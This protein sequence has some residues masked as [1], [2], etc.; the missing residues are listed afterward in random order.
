VFEMVERNDGLAR[1]REAPTGRPRRGLAATGCIAA[2]AFTFPVTASAQTA[3]APPTAAPSALASALEQQVARPGGLT[4]DRAA[5]RARTTSYDV[6]ARHADAAAA[7][8]GSTQAALGFLPRLT[9]KG[10]YMRLSDV[11]TQSLGNVVVAPQGTP[12]GPVGSG[13]SLTNVPLGFT[14]PNDNYALEADL[15]IPVSDYLLRLADQYAS[16]K[17][18]AH[19]AEYTA[20]A[21]ELA[22]AR[23]ARVLYYGW[24][25]AKLA[26]VVAEASLALAKEHLVDTQ[27]RFAAVQSSRADVLQVESLLAER[28][29]FVER[30]RNAL[31]AADDR[32]RT[33]L[34]EEGRAPYEIGEPLLADLPPV[35][36]GGDFAALVDEALRTRWELRAVREN[37]ESLRAQAS[38][39]RASLYPRLD[40]VGSAVYANPN[41][42]YFP[43]PGDWRGTWAVGGAITWSS[44][45]AILGGAGGATVDARADAAAAQ[46]NALREGLRSEVMHAFEGLHDADAALSATAR[47]LTAAEESYR[48]R[49]SLFR[50]GAAT[51]TELTDA[52]N[53]LTRARFDALNARIDLRVARAELEHATGRDDAR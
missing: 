41:P 32:L 12:L 22:A 11:G 3:E 46:E 34:H 31:V 4:A 29:L 43:P 23:D 26:F 19:A 20:H 50:V 45:D 51:S 38:T 2:A 52:E 37:T 18:A 25:R 24:A 30:A 39:A 7:R 21:A 6:K 35:T 47:S 5:T 17:H 27:A 9:A 10:S 36:G 42:R 33:T 40:A 28:E 49:R 14:F 13:A 53:A 1:R 44:A 16:A 15:L 8:A 48:V